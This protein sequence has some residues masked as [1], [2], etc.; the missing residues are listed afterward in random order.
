MAYSCWIDV[1]NLDGMFCCLDVIFG[2]K[3]YGDDCC[4][5]FFVVFCM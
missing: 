1:I 4:E 2:D 5:M 3:M